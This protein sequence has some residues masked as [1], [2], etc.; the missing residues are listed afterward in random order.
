MKKQITIDGEGSDW[1]EKAIFILRDK[2]ESHIPDDLFLYAEQIVENYLKKNPSAAYFNSTP[3]ISA[4]KK[5]CMS[6]IHQKKAAK[7]AKM[8]NYF[9]NISL[10]VCGISIIAVALLYYA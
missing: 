1:Y 9:F 3:Q 2:K 7:R 6:S 8:I 5:Q 10:I 4:Q